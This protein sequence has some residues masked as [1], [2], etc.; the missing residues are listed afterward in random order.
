V[1]LLEQRK[2]V[3]RRANREDMRESLLSLTGAGRS[4]YEDL[5]PVALDFTRKLVD[6]IEPGDRLVF[7]RVLRLLTERSA[8]LIGESAK[9]KPER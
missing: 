7:D 9:A 5:V 4:V 6:A 3:T 8:A 1:A 2:L